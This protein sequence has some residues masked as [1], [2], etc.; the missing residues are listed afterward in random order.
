[1]TASCETCLARM[2]GDF[3][4]SPIDVTE[5]SLESGEN[6]RL[7]MTKCIRYWMEMA[8]FLRRPSIYCAFGHLH[9]LRM[10]ENGLH[11]KLFWSWRA[12]MEETKGQIGVLIGI[13]W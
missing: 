12:I 6:I 4:H 8:A 7:S 11:F 2:T 10:P 9:V 1:M 3:M 5:I 13:L